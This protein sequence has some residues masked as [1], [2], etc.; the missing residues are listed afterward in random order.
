MENRAIVQ[1]PHVTTGVRG[2]GP[3]SSKPSLMEE[4]QQPKVRAGQPV[5]LLHCS[6]P[7]HPGSTVL[8][9]PKQLWEGRQTFLSLWIES[10]SE[11][12]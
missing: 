9:T 12:G 2:L 8:I 6:Q 4:A 5:S 7:L 10:L 1:N 11:V 3:L